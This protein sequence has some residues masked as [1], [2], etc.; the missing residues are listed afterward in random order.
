MDNEG[1]ETKFI[2]KTALECGAVGFIGSHPVNRLKK[3]IKKT[4]EWI[5][6]E[7]DKAHNVVEHVF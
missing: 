1:F 6:K 2:M 3:G 4:Y 5:S 7:I